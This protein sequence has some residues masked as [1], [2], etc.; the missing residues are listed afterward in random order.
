LADVTLALERAGG[1][2]GGCPG[3]EDLLAFV[4]RIPKPATDRWDDLSR[5]AER[6]PTSPV[7]KR[8]RINYAADLA[9]FRKRAESLVDLARAEGRNLYARDG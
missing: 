1:F 6:L 3:K 5:P 4:K 2:P 8:W 7:W 9:T